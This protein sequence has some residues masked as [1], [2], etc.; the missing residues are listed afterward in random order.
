MQPR[1]SVWYNIVSL[2]RSPWDFKERWKAPYI[3]VSD[4]TLIHCGISA[5]ST[6]SHEQQLKYWYQYMKN[7]KDVNFYW[8]VICFGNLYIN[9]NAKWQNL[10][11]HM[12]IHTDTHTHPYVHTHTHAPTH[13]HAWM[14]T[15]THTL[16]H[17]HTTHTQIHTHLHT[18]E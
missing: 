8:Q 7:Y 3:I 6:S 4:L 15:H 5:F 14:N 13:M 1:K 17:T 16:T 12:Q 10:D 18:H 9:I 2:P 11:T